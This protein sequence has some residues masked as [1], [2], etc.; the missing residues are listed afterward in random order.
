MTPLPLR[1]SFSDVLSEASLGDLY[2][3]RRNPANLSP[4]RQRRIDVEIAAREAAFSR[5]SLDLDMLRATAADEA[6]LT[7]RKAIAPVVWL[8][9]LVGFLAGACAAVI[10]LLI[11]RLV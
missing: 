10:V 3:M 2:G 9:L 6:R 8:I 5:N 4:E 1:K 7:V 11:F